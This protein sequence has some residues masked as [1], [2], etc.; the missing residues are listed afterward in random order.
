M[1]AERRGGAA[2]DAELALKEPTEFAK[3]RNF[4]AIKFAL[5]HEG[6]GDREQAFEWLEKAYENREFP[7]AVLKV[8]EVLQTL[9]DDPCFHDLLRRIG[10]AS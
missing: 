4:P 3:Q 5:I 10:F 1:L 6:L 8:A 7:M 2:G 9:R